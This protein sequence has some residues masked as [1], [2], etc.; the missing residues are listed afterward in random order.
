MFFKI[1]GKHNYNHYKPT[2]FLVGIFVWNSPTNFQGVANGVVSFAEKQPKWGHGFFRPP[3]T[4]VSANLLQ[5]KKLIFWAAFFR[6]KKGAWFTGSPKMLE[7][8]H[9]LGS[10]PI[11]VA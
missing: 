9:I 10:I 3:G 11:L 8:M 5:I 4:E 1:N 2:V 7:I 6:M